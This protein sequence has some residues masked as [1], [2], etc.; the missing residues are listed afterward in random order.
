MS[1]RFPAR[2]PGWPRLP[3]AASRSGLCPSTATSGLRALF[4]LFLIHRPFLAEDL[5]NTGSLQ[6][7]LMVGTDR[8]PVGHIYTAGRCPVQD[9]RQIGVGHG[10]AIE[11]EL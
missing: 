7:P 2:K 8:G 5:C 6:H 3:R 1:L 11:Q 10:K 9:G 4:L